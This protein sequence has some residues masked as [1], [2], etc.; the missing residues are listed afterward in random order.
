MYMSS[1]ILQDSKRLFCKIKKRR[2]AT[3]RQFQTIHHEQRP[4]HVPLPLCVPPTTHAVKEAQK[5]PPPPAL[6]HHLHRHKVSGLATLVVTG[7]AVA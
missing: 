6:R 1:T 2:R 5:D 3:T 7:A 4:I